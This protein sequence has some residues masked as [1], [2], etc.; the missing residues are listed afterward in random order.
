MASDG[1]FF[2]DTME[3]L[4]QAGVTA[5]IQPGGSKADPD[6]IRFADEHNMAVVFTGIRNFRH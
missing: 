1:F 6:V 2:E 4:H 5:V 3:L